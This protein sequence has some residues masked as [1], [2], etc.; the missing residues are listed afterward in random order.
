MARSTRRLTYGRALAAMLVFSL[1]LGTASGLGLGLAER[2]GWPDPAG[3]VVQAALCTLITLVGIIWLARRTGSSAESYGFRRARIGRD[4][5]IG[6]A[7]VAAAALMVVVPTAVLG[8]IRFSGIDP[9]PL[10]IYLATTVVV[11]TGLEAFPEELAFR[12]FAYSSLRGRLQPTLAATVAT[13]IFVLAP[14][15]SMVWTA[16]IA[17]ALGTGHPQWYAI[18]PPGEDP[19]SYVMLLVLWSICLL[20]A[21][22]VT[23]SIWVGVAAHLLL[24]VVNR[25]LLGSADGSGVELAHPDLTLII[26]AYVVLATIA[27][28]LLRG[29][30]R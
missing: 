30:F 8:G 13:V 6:F 22:Q 9:V 29:R 19:V 26:P 14:G 3:S 24:L 28:G 27:F 5:G 12:G 25:T 17:R 4:L 23:D 1:A 7:V 10:L 11:A 18:A 2:L 15:L 16:L 21:R 20:Q